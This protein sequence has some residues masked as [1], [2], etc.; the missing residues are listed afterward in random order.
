MAAD[1]TT[2]AAAFN[3]CAPAQHHS[4]YHSLNVHNIYRENIKDKLHVAGGCEQHL[5]CSS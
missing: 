1:S 4:S 2:A 3:L 5:A